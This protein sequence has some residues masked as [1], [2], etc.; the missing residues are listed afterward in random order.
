MYHV[1]SHVIIK[2]LFVCLHFILLLDLA[3]L[4]LIAGG[5]QQIFAPDVT[6]NG[7]AGIFMANFDDVT[8]EMAILNKIVGGLLL[9]IGCMLFTVRWNPTN[10]KLAGIACI[11]CSFN[12]G[13]TIFNALDN[14][15]F[16]P[17]LFYGYAV[18]LAFA[19]LHIMF[20][21]NPAMKAADDK[22]E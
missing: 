6:A 9:V 5:L 8:H 17:R 22:K 18:I 21:P 15:V 11:A 14:G 1:V 7:F 3:A 10:G 12:M 16:Y 2:F 4:V 19:G 20:N 13:H